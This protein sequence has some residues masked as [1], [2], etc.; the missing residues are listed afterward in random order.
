MNPTINTDM[1]SGFYKLIIPAF[2]LVIMASCSGDKTAQ[3]EKLKAKQAELAKE[4]AALEKEIPADTSAASK[5]KSKDVAVV[6]IAPR[7]FDHYIQTQGKIDSEDNIMVSAKSPGVI[8]QVFVRE[9]DQVSK[10]QTLA[11]IDNTLILRSIEEMNSIAKIN[12][13]PL[14]ACRSL[15]QSLEESIFQE[16]G[17]AELRS[18]T[19]FY[20]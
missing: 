20:T 16:T 9:G 6:D 18:Y 2:A 8:T 10:G 14:M 15:K 13:R 5:V 7:K 12:H 11:Q 4:I 3:L 19:Y 1:K 17:G